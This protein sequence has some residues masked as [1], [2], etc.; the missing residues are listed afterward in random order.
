MNSPDQFRITRDQN[1]AVFE[2][3]RDLK[4]GEKITFEVEATLKANDPE[5]ADFI[6]EAYV[7]DGYVLDRD[8][9]EPEGAGM[10]GMP[11][12]RT[13]TSMYVRRKDAKGKRPV[14]PPPTAPGPP[15]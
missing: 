11:D 9:E 6:A 8:Q 7:P 14:A 12:G 10:T 5:G 1:P 2:A 15:V 3:I 4:V 13:P